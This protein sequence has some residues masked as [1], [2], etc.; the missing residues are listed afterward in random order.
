MVVKV[1]K[2]RVSGIGESFA[3]AGRVFK[4]WVALPRPDRARWRALLLEGIEFVGK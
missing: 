2:E 4:E 1:G 3:P